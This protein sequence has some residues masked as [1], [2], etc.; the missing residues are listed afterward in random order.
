V[1]ESA[2]EEAGS[3][4]ELVRERIEDGASVAD[5]RSLSL[6]LVAAPPSPGQRLFA[7]VGRLGGAQPAGAR[8]KGGADDQTSLGPDIELLRPS[9]DP[10][11][12]GGFEQQNPEPDQKGLRLPQQTS[13]QDRRVLSP[14]RLGPLSRAMKFHRKIPEEAIIIACM[15]LF[16]V[17][18]LI[19]AIRQKRIVRNAG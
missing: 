4:A 12:H 19:F 14:R 1:G 8:E 2:A 15:A 11:A 9:S 5:Q 13:L 18:L 10:W 16:S 6:V 7:R 17:F 3:M